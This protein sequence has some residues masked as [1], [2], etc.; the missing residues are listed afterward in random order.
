[1]SSAAR[2]TGRSDEAARLAIHA[3][4]DAGILV[5]NAKNRKSGIYAARD[6]LDAFTAY[7]RALATPGGDTA[8]AKPTRAVALRVPRER[9]GK[10]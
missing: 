10:K 1:M 5:Q 7:E 6:A 3:L 2:L 8:T 9:R 4:V